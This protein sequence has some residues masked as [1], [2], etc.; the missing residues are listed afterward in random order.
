MLLHCSIAVQQVTHIVGFVQRPDAGADISQPC[1]TGAIKLNPRNTAPSGYYSEWTLSQGKGYE[2]GGY[3]Y[4]DTSQLDYCPQNGDYILF[5][6]FINIKGCRFDDSLKIHIEDF[7][8]KIKT[9]IVLPVC[10]NSALA[11]GSCP[12]KNGKAQ[13]TVIEPAGGGG[14]PGR[15]RPGPVWHR[16]CRGDPGYRHH[17]GAPAPA[18]PPGTGTRLLLRWRPRRPRSRAAP[19]PRPSSPPSSRSTSCRTPTRPCVTSAL[20]RTAASGVR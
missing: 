6:S 9:R 20:C 7:V 16:L 12:G 8:P 14:L 18:A 10:G 5:Y 2:V 4:P 15:H 11:L 13:W 19:P 17:P 1:Y 3:F